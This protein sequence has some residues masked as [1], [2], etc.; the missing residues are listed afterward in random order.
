M[1]RPS[2]R[3]IRREVIDHAGRAIR[4]RGVDGFSYGDLARRLGIRAPSIHHH[5]GR[6]DDLIAATVA[7]YRRAFRVEV[8]SLP[9][10]PP[11]E[12]L[13]AYADLFLR[14]ADDAALCLCGA[15]V[16]GWD[17]VDDA[18]RSEV[19]GF[20]DDELDWWSAS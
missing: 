2:G 5:F 8:E 13:G 10:G 7:D 16:A 4:S 12:R 15:V 17:Q 14:S 11:L 6:K 1:A 20:F 9:P 18:A 19:A 3:D